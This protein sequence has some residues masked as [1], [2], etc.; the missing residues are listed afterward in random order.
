[1]RRQCLQTSP[2]GEI[3]DDNGLVCCSA[4]EKVTFG[5]ESDG[6]NVEGVL[7]ENAKALA[8]AD[9]PYA[10]CQIVGTQRDYVAIY[11]GICYV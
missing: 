7:L 8:L 10:N 9:R 11:G 2:R 3:P 5:V 1:M 4:D 6:G